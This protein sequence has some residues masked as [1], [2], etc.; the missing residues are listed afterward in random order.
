[1]P[2]ILHFDW[3]LHRWHAPIWTL[4]FW[5][6]VVF[7]LV[8]VRK[9]VS[10]EMSMLLVNAVDLLLFHMAFPRRWSRD[11]FHVEADPSTATLLQTVLLDWAGTLFRP[12]IVH[13]VRQLVAA[14][15][16]FRAA[17]AAGLGFW[18]WAL[19]WCCHGHWRSHHVQTQPLLLVCQRRHEREMRLHAQYRVVNDSSLL[20]FFL[21]F[22]VAQS[23][24]HSRKCVFYVDRQYNLLMQLYWL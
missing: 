20:A 24:W 7:A 6:V 5:R 10:R 16:A 21:V 14:W 11:S 18:S 9:H 8:A 2:Q 13:K 19:C 3:P 15:F 22:Q 1:M 17:W 12:M 23:F 4:I